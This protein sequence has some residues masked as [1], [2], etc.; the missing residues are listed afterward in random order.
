MEGQTGG[1]M[2]ACGSGNDEGICETSDLAQVNQCNDECYV[3]QDQLSPHVCAL[4]VLL[5]AFC[6]YDSV[7]VQ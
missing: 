7:I 6:A 5:E 1:R 2:D 4:V 3:E